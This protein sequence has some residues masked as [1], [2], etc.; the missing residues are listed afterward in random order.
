MGIN[1][2]EVKIEVV[3]RRRRENIPTRRNR[4]ERREKDKRVERRDV[5]IAHQPRVG[6]IIDVVLAQRTFLSN[7]YGAC[8]L[9]SEDG[10][11]NHS[12][13]AVIVTHKVTL[14]TGPGIS[15]TW[16]GALAIP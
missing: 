9:V 5:S 8:F 12:K 4:A 15:T 7:P 6:R 3:E 11:F 1:K 13:T 16:S 14:G 2:E 10:T